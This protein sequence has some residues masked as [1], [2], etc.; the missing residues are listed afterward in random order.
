MNHKIEGDPEYRMNIEDCFLDGY[1]REINQ[2]ELDKAMDDI[3]KIIDEQPPK[4]ND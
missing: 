2:K 3:K 1:G 4:E